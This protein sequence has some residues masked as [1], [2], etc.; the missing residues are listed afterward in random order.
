MIDTR[1]PVSKDTQKKLMLLKYQF[2]E[3]TVD[4]VIQK[5]MK[6]LQWEGLTF[7]QNLAEMEDAQK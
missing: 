5:L 4:E 2:G 1:I 3:K 7:R 6:N